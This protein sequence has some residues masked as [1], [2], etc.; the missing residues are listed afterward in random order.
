M[1]VGSAL[2]FFLPFLL[3]SVEGGFTEDD[4]CENGMKAQSLI[5]AG[6]VPFWLDGLVLSYEVC[7]LSARCGLR[8]VADA[9]CTQCWLHSPQPVSEVVY[10]HNS[11]SHYHTAFEMV[12]HALRGLNAPR[13]RKSCRFSSDRLLF[14]SA[15]FSKV[16]CYTSNKSEAMLMSAYLTSRAWQHLLH[17]GFAVGWF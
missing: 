13:C 8:A 7:F 5:K 2:F 9:A 12:L 1:F 3:S 6:A 11:L 14:P 4:H 15:R 16:A 10:Y 17:Q